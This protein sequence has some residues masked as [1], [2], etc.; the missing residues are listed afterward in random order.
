MHKGT[1]Q[2]TGESQF[3]SR[4]FNQSS[5]MDSGFG[6]DDDYSTYSKPLFDRSEGTG[7]YR[8]KRDDADIYGDVDSQ[9]AKLSD[10]SKFKP[11]KGFAGTQGAPTGGGGRTAPV[12][13]EKTRSVVEDEEDAFEIG[14]II[15]PKRARKD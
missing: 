15:Q 8:P 5:G 3:D 6:A 14:D 12:Q 2:L 13:F 10:T 4:L 7:I 1:G 11:D 9:M